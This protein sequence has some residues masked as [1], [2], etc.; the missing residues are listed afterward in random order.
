MPT[1]APHSSDQATRQRLLHAAL[2][3]FAE[4]G[5]SRASV[6]EIAQAAEA[7]VAAVSYYFGDKQG[8]YRAAF[9]E[10]MGSP[11]DDI[12]LFDNPGLGLRQALAGLFSGFT[13]PLQCGELAQLCTRL[14]MREM[15][16]PT[17]AWA[18]EI[19]H[20]IKPYTAALNALLCRH[21][22]LARADDDLHRLAFS[23][24][25]LGM[26]LYMGRDVVQAVRPTL[27]ASSQALDLWAERLVEHALAMVQAEARRR[28]L[29]PLPEDKAPPP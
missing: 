16:E 2:R 11:R 13:E 6:R 18:D 17:G 3:L 19:D 12:A 21:F 27:L 8:L 4:Q 5:Y 23:I 22:R 24:V 1:R 9:T 26:F 14:H 29:P 28:G 15:V 25:S 7:N 20:G 10:P